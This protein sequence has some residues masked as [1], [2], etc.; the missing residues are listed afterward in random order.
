MKLEITM[1]LNNAAFEDNGADEIRRILRDYSRSLSD[2]LQDERWGN[3]PLVDSN[4]NHCGTA[5]IT[6]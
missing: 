2:N 4:G 5:E 6:E 1:N 3:K